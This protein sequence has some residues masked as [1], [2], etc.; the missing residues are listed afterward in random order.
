[1]S[2]K[3]VIGLFDVVL[4][5]TQD[6]R[7]KK[8]FCLPLVICSS[9]FDHSDEFDHTGMMLEADKG[10]KLHSRIISKLIELFQ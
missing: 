3:Q 9:V 4:C 10:I 7:F 6:P 1:M 5:C 2:S 8:M